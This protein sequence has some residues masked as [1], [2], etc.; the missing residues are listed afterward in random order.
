MGVP[1]PELPPT[2]PARAAGLARV[3]VDDEEVVFDPVHRRAHRLNPTA[4]MVLDR[5]DGH[6]TTAEVCR[7]LSDQFGAGLDQI[8]DDLA[9]ILADFT[10]RQLVSPASGGAEVAGRSA[11]DGPRVE[12]PLAVPDEAV[13]TRRYV[14]GPLP[15]LDV[16]AVVTT[17]DDGLALEVAE[18]LG[19]LASVAASPG[20]AVVYEL[21]AAERGIDVRADGRAIGNARNADSALSL[22]QWH[23]NR[24]VGEHSGGRLQLHASAVRLRDGRVAVFPGDVNA[25]KSTLVAGL[26]RAGYGYLTDEMVAVEIGTGRAEGYRKPVNL[27]PGAWSL[28]PGVVPT[29]AADRGDEH[30]V[31][32]VALHPDALAGPRT[33][34]IG[35]VVFPAY[36]AGGS[37]QATRLSPGAAL[38]TLIAH[39]TNLATHGQA[40]LDTLARLVTRAADFDLTMAG[41]DDAV[42]AVDA[43][44]AGLPAVVGASETD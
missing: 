44:V 35:L 34:G 15:A 17:D 20:H 6:T 3:A 7:D 1:T 43:L 16:T 10:G 41:L 21:V 19:S 25:G 33:G 2:M 29:D 32:P 40:G 13:R 12:E 42:R 4:A 37:T 39:C 30:L 22:V 5:C 26:V 31:D 8:A 38:V 28:F 18:R 27:D 23:L 36:R 24:L 11:P 14:T 9:S